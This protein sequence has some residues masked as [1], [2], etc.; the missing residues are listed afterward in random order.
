MRDYWF[1]F[2]LG[3]RYV[4]VDENEEALKRAVGLIG[5]ISVAIDSSSCQNGFQFYNN[6]VYVCNSCST[7]ELDHS[8]LAVGYGND[9]GTDYWL[10][11]NSFGKHWG[12]N[13]FIKMSRNKNNQCGIATLP[14]YPIMKTS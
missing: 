1:E 5:P 4:W 13:G 10:V 3:F 11:K 14:I 6:G 8:L 2:L 7:T 9:S 12:E